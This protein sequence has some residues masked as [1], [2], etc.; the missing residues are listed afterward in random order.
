ME[1]PNFSDTFLTWYFKSLS[2][3]II[4]VLGPWIGML[5]MVVL[6]PPMGLDEEASFEKNN[7]FLCVWFYTI[8]IVL[9]LSPRNFFLVS[10]W[11]I[12]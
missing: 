7:L 9:L 11:V 1:L 4:L 10:V 12:R 2:S 6:D 3:L 5:I 8:S